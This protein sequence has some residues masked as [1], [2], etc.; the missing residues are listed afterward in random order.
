[1]PWCT[2]P[3]H[4]NVSAW[5]KVVPI[6]GFFPF[7][8]YWLILWKQIKGAE[9]YKSIKNKK[10]NV[11]LQIKKKKWEKK[12]LTPPLQPVPI[13]VYG[14]CKRGKWS[15][16]VSPQVPHV[17]HPC[18]A[19]GRSRFMEPSPFPGD[20]LH[21]LLK[22]EKKSLFPVNFPLPAGWGS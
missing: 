11:T 14:V 15:W 10:K 20:Q 21:L 19:L 6:R 1:M 9:Y 22:Q 12:N 17:W 4:S 13:L 2:F 16:E 5:A 3:E 8:I 7:D 18:S